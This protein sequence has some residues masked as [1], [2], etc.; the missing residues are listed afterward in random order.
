MPAPNL[1]TGL[2]HAI[3][4]VAVNGTL[5]ESDIIMTL[6]A[7]V[8]YTAPVDA[9][10]SKL[11]SPPSD[12]QAA[13]DVLK[14]VIKMRTD[15][16]L[17]HDM[18][19]YLS[20][21][22]RLQHTRGQIIHGLWSHGTDQQG[23]HVA[24]SMRNPTRPT[25]MTVADMNNFGTKIHD[26]RSTLLPILPLL[27]AAIPETLMHIRPTDMPLDARWNQTGVA[28]NRLQEAVDES[29]QPLYVAT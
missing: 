6:W 5:L 20:E 9:F 27:G 1:P 15:G 11:I 3:G 25:K 28:W 18:L 7:A 22:K 8:S 10:G 29:G 26:H 4:R 14:G 24:T 19:T 17:K 13:I 2:V 12:I 16:P 23:R 21:A